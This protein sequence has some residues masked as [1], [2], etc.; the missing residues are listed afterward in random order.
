MNAP[1]YRIVVLIAV[2]WLV[3]IGALHAQTAIT[4]AITGYVQDASGAVLTGATVEA[5]DTATAVTDQTVTNLAGLYRFTGLVPGIYS[6]SVKKA[7]FEQVIRLDI[8]VD[9]GTAVPIDVTLP[10]GSAT[11]TVTVSGQTPLLQTD[12]VAISQTIQA[13]QIAR[14]PIFGNN[15][16]RLALLAPGVSMPSGQLDLHPEN[17][18]EDFNVVINGGQ[19]NNNAHILDGVDNTEV[20]QGL[21]L[22]VPTAASVQEVK[23]TTSNYDV[24]YGSV[25]GAVFQTTTKSGTNGF[26]GSVFYYY[27]TAG[28]FAADSFSEP[29]GV[30]GNVWNQFGGSL[31]AQSKETSYS[32]LPI[33]K[34]CG[35]IWQLQAFTHR[36][37]PHFVL[38]TLAPSQKPTRSTIRPRAMPTEPDEHS[39][40]T[41]KFRQIVS[42]RQRRIFWRCCQR[43]RTPAQQIIILRSPARVFST[44]IKSMRVWTFSPLPRPSFLGS[45]ATFMRIF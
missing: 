4:G 6:I 32:S 16:T 39:F 9:A 41:T 33:T 23:V 1:V 18:G 17:A 36:R 12:T 22:L 42:A 21:S 31:G 24:E 30:P 5:T 45:S 19:T 13:D 38:E 25:S 11:T 10:V 15:I 44:R 34:E 40:R 29:N 3:Y 14:L 27:R 20:I 28:F 26:H 43:R 7:G 35:T 2:L 37:S 8:T